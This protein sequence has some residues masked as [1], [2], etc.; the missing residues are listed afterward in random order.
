MRTIICTLALVFSASLCLAGCESTNPA[1][2]ASAKPFLPANSTPTNLRGF[3]SEDIT[4]AKNLYDAKCA[5][6]HKF[7]DPAAYKDAEWRTWMTKMSKKA[8]L[9]PE[10]SDLLSRYLDGF[11]N[12]PSKQDTP[13]P[14]KP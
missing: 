7:Y 13:N 3:S 9:K 14:A 1:P 6:C 5:R 8:H 4:R 12:S 2:H 10:Q 11:R